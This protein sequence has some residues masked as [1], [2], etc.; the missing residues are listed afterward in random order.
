MGKWQS[1]Y[2][3]LGHCRLWFVNDRFSDMN[4]YL[5]TSL[6]FRLIS[7]FRVVL[8]PNL[9]F[10]STEIT[11][12][13]SYKHTLTHTN[14]QKKTTTFPPASPRCLCTQIPEFEQ[15]RVFISLL[16]REYHTSQPFAFTYSMNKEAHQQ[17][18]LTRR[19]L[20]TPHN[21]SVNKYLRVSTAA[22]P[23]EIT[24][25][26]WLNHH[27]RTEPFCHCSPAGQ[28]LNYIKKGD[29]MGQR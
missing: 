3:I 5:L 20:S 28:G 10:G 25:L 12:P 7:Y 29:V 23:H 8:W 21:K 1:D 16:T 6:A 13:Y 15:D 18:T 26:N 11:K 14:T 9:W 17:P 27:L 4:V 22:S 2:F 19:N 24:D